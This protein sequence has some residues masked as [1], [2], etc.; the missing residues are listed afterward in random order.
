M[1]YVSS[2]QVQGGQVLEIKVSDPGSSS[3]TVDLTPLVASFNGNDI[4]LV[5]VQDG[6]W[7]AYLADLSQATVL[8]ALTDTDFGKDCV[9][10]LSSTAVGNVEFNIDTVNAFA[11][12]ATCTDTGTT[13]KDS[14]FDVL[15]NEMKFV[16]KRSTSNTSAPTYQGQVSVDEGYW[17]FIHT[18]N[19]NDDNYHNIW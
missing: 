1:L 17:P 13:A 15:V 18:I 3:V 19:F 4:K 11:E 2:T 9:K 7:M 8:D 16:G 14:E 12:D 6:S 5:Q 10:T